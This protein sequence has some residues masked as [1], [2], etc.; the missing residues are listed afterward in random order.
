MRLRDER[1]MMAIG[2]ALMLIVVLALFGGALWQYSMF[3]LRRVE[4]A[5]QDMQALFLAR[6]G[7][8]AVMGAWRM[9]IDP[10]KRPLGQMDALYYDTEHDRLT[11]V[12][13]SSYLGSVDVAVRLEDLSG[14][15]DLV[16]VI[17]STAKVGSVTRTVRLTTYPYRYGHDEKL[18]WY[19]GGDGRIQRPKGQ[20]KEPV[21][22]RA[23]SGDA[24]IYADSKTL[25]YRSLAFAASDLIFESSLQLLRAPYPGLWLDPAFTLRLEAER[26]FFRGL[27]VAYL[28]TYVVDPKSY[29]VVL[30]LPT[31][32][33]GMGEPG[34]EVQ[35]KVAGGNVIPDARYGQVYF[36]AGKGDYLLKVARSLSSKWDRTVDLDTNLKGK[37]FFFRDSWK[38]DPE[39]IIEEGVDEYFRK[40]MAD[41]DLLPILPQYQTNREALK[42]LRP[43]FWER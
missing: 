34:E 42:S 18:G 19:L 23:K 40:A 5:E 41:G 7:A 36:D 33:E 17:E 8:E 1:G 14:E 13:P 4:Q 22:M 30:Q 29:T 16:T 24:P 25:E 31:G 10:E 39:R 3:E 43:F 26:I 21:I 11:V 20:A 2:V 6:A 32:P 37:A 9:E 35:G 28:D 27:Q 15:G 38:L 12:K